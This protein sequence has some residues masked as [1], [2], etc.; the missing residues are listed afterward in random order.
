MIWLRRALDGLYL[1]AGMMAGVFLI[2]ILVMMMA[3]SIGREFSINIKS[4]DD[5]TAWCMAAMSFLGLAHTFKSGE[6]IRV[7]L[8]TERLRGRTK[9]AFEVFALAMAAIFIGFFAW[10][11]IDQNMLSWKLNDMSQGVLA[12]PLWIPQL[13]F[14]SG[15]VILLIAIVDEL[16]RVLVGLK[17]TYEKEPPKTAEELIERAVASGV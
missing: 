8:L 6:M 16:C 14:T 17:P 11:A 10:H 9:W 1:G 2:A 3:M 5:I 15:I 7:G 13:G 12:I 4:G